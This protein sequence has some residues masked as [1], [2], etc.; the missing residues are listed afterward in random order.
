LSNCGVSPIR[1]PWCGRP[2]LSAPAV[3][4]GDAEKR[5]QLL[6]VVQMLAAEAEGD[7]DLMRVEFHAVL[8]AELG[9]VR[10][11]RPAG[12]GHDWPEPGP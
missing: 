12:R 9:L 8:L 2:R 3:E 7:D 1:R 4:L 6:T 5:R 10:C 11:V